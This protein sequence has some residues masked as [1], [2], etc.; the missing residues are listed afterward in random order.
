MKRIRQLLTPAAVLAAVL[1]IF[2]AP[3]A[4]AAELWLHVHVDEGEDGATVKVNLPISFVEKALT[5]VPTDEMRDGRIVIDDEEITVAELRELWTSLRDSAGDAV[6]VE[7]HDDDERVIVRRQGGY[8]LV[9]VEED[10]QDA[11]VN[12]RI[13]ER[14]I[15][16]MLAT[17]GEELDLAAGLRALAD[18]GEGELVAV[19]DGGDH[20]RVWIDGRAESR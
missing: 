16:A 6:L 11:K 14:V 2:A 5:M 18:E 15:E 9:E 4:Q 1:L 3:A 10:G 8:M 19:N 17:G 7:T 13:P 12:V 20:V